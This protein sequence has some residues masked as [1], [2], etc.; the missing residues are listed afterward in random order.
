MTKAQSAEQSAPRAV[1][2]KV[3][4]TVRSKMQGRNSKA[5]ASRITCRLL[6]HS[7]SN[8]LSPRLESEALKP[9][10]LFE[11]LSVD[12]NQHQEDGAHAHLDP[13]KPRCKSRG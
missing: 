6:S 4:F 9:K 2:A 12:A 11:L 10:A 1:R 5:A 7:S 8:I 3:S 13:P